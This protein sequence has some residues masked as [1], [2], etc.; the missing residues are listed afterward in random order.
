M[1]KLSISLAVLAVVFAISSAFTTQKLT[2]A[3]QVWYKVSEVPLN[4]FMSNDFDQASSYTFVSAA[5]SADYFIEESI[6][7][8]LSE[9]LVCAVRLAETSGSSLDQ[10][11]LDAYINGTS[12]FTTPR[13]TPDEIVYKDNQ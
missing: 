12:P 2:S 4:S 10:T 8:D 11:E 6:C 5:T 9:D 7:D 1:K 3:A 13:S